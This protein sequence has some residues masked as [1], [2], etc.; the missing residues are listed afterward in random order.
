M[1]VLG[2]LHREF[3]SLEHVLAELVRLFGLPAWVSETGRPVERG[4]SS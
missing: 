3:V 1:F 2:G 4:L